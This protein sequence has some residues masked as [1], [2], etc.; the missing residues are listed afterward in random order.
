MQNKSMNK[1]YTASLALIVLTVCAI[2]YGAM[3][4][5]NGVSQETPVVA[6][7]RGYIDGWITVTKTDGKTGEVTYLAKNEHNVLTRVG[8][9]AIRDLIGGGTAGAA[10]DYIALGNNTNVTTT[11]IALWDEINETG[12]ARAQGTT[13]LD[14]V[15]NWTLTHIFTS[16]SN[17]IIVNTTGVYNHTSEDDN[18]LLAGSDFT[19]ATLQSSDTIQ[20]TWAF[21]VT[22]G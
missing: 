11:S 21:N 4:F 16:Q 6:A 5:S 12:L 17:D 13:Y 20:I 1:K 10:F 14:G 15:G 8:A 18:M 19:S 7:Q 2:G 9:S 22:G 3:A